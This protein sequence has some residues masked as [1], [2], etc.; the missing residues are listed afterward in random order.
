M[1]DIPKKCELCRHQDAVKNSTYCDP[2][3]AI[4]VWQNSVAGLNPPK[5]IF[6]QTFKNN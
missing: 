6:R 1:N 3:L 2:C 4:R 5:V